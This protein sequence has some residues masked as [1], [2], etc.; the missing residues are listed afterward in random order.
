ME[1]D[2]FVFSVEDFK[3]SSFMENEAKQD[4]S[5]FKITL[6]VAIEVRNL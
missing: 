5:N 3:C 4:K 6:T 1:M 2:F